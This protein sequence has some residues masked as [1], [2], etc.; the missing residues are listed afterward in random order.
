MGPESARDARD[1]ATGEW[2]GWASEPTHGLDDGFER[3]SYPEDCGRA[4][5][6]V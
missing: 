4:E 5:G 6:G 3:E 1:M 2:L